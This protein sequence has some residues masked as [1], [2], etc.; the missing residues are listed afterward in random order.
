[1][2]L[3]CLMC[4][5]LETT[6][7]EPVPTKVQSAVREVFKTSYGKKRPFWK[8]RKVT[9]TIDERTDFVVSSSRKRIFTVVH[10]INI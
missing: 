1:M 10:Y 8:T 4:L 5:S 6:P 2:I 3:E 7:L 9:V